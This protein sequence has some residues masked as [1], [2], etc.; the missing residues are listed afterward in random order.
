MGLVISLFRYIYEDIIRIFS[1]RDVVLEEISKNMTNA[2]SYEEWKKFALQYDTRVGND[3]WRKEI[4]SDE[5]DYMLIIKRTGSLRTAIETGDI[6]SVMHLIRAGLVRGIGGISKGSLH[7][8]SMAGTKVLI[9]DYI[10]TMCEGIKMLCDAPETYFTPITKKRFFG[11]MRQAYGRTAVLLSGGSALGLHHFGVIKCMYECQMLPKIICGASIGALLAGLLAVHTK[12][13]IPR[14][15]EPNS[16]NFGAFEKLGPG[17]ARRKIKRFLKHGHLMNAERL[18]E[19]CISNIG[20]YTFLEAFHRTFR[21]VNIAVVG[22]NRNEVPWLLNYLTAPNVLV[23]SAAVASCAMPGVFAPVNILAKDHEGNIVPWNPSKHYFS[24]MSLEHDLPMNRLSEL[25]NVN[26]FVVS[27]VNPHVVPFL[28]LFSRNDTDK[29]HITRGLERLR[30][31]ALSELHHIA[32]NLSILVPRSFNVLQHVLSQKYLADITIT[33]E[34]CFDTDIR[35]LLRNPSEDLFRQ[36]MVRGKSS[37]YKYL[38]QLQTNTKIEMMIEE[39]LRVLRNSS[40]TKKNQVTNGN[41]EPGTENTSIYQES[42]SS[43]HDLGSSVVVS[44]ETPNVFTP[45]RSM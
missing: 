38:P 24:D 15:F 7:R 20:N 30:D 25:F 29:L 10:D 13:E 33:P 34:L 31:V 8:H 2:N 16:I 19:F 42:G 36:S 39:C 37:T 11:D 6:T 41:A 22:R 21:T 27:Q 5:Y 1:S 4:M 45:R 28:N 14:L 26:H 3:K 32:I 18:Q 43:L 17:S 12:E 44:G 9:E 40:E 35:N 23:W